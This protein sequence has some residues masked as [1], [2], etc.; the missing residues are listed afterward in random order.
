MT[1]TRETSAT[2]VSPADTLS[3]QGQALLD[4]ARWLA[5]AGAAPFTAAVDL[6]A[7]C[8]ASGGSVLISGLGKSGLVGAKFAATLSSLGIPAHAVHPSEAAH[9]D[10]GRFRPQDTVICLS[11]SGQTDEVINLAAILRQD[12]LPIISIT[13][14]A[15]GSPPSDLETL[16][17]VS[18]RLPLDR[19]A[20]EPRFVA[21]TTSTTLTMAIGDALALAVADRL[22]FTDAEFRRRHPGGSL[23]GLL[24]PVIEMLRFKAGQN[25]PLIPQGLSVADALCLAD[26]PGRRPGAM[27]IIDPA[28]RRLT[29]IFTDGDLRRLV[30][31]QPA[32]LNAPIESVMTRSPRTLPDTALVRDAVTMIRE[33]RQDEI[34]VVGPQGQP[35]GILDVQDLIA[36]RL[37]KD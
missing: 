28:S 9:G 15:P 18:L 30:L 19:E 25:L 27:V 16:S 21:P 29:G 20:G 12:A 1:P 10:L 37:V 2:P 6:L 34:P 36:M 5:G 32:A 33:Y 22:Q 23:G 7:R 14:P 26:A 35:V 11:K 31:R 8:A 3:A 13:A 17:T 4:A 24:R